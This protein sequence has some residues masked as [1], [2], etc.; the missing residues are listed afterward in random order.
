LEEKGGEEEM[1]RKA[2]LLTLMVLGVL[3]LSLLIGG[4]Y[5]YFDDTETSTGNVFTAGTLNLVSVINGAE[6]SGHVVVNEQGDGLNDNV[7]FGMVAPGDSGSITWTLTNVGN[8]DGTRTMAALVDGHENG[9]NEPELAGTVHNV[10][11]DG[12]LD[13]ALDVELFL[14]AT[15]LYD[16]DL[17]GLAAFL[18]GYAGETMVGDMGVTSLVYTLQWAVD[19]PT[20]GNEIQSDDATLAVTFTLNQVP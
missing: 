11:G 12:D 8:V 20:V 1:K 13:D 19:G 5:G 9:E 16:G 15:S 2:R 7:T 14:G 4:L 18:A 10:G 6:A 3:M 17:D